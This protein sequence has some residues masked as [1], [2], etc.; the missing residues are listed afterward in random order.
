M[1]AE[2]IEIK[3]SRKKKPPR[4]PKIKIVKEKVK[5]EPIKKFKLVPLTRDELMAQT[6]MTITWD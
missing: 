4:E 2:E 3:K 6:T 1:S 5:K